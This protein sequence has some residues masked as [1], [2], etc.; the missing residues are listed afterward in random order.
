MD[1]DRNRLDTDELNAAFDELFP[2]GL[3][4]DDVKRILAPQGWANSPLLAV[5]HPS[6]QQQF[7]ESTRMHENLASLRKPGDTKPLSEPPTLEEFTA[8]AGP[9]EIRADEEVCRLVGMA[10]WDVFSD[11]HEVTDADGRLYDLG[12]FRG[13]GGFL[14]DLLNRHIGEGRTPNPELDQRNAELDAQLRKMM[15]GNDL[16]FE[17]LAK[18]NT[19][20]Y[21]YTDFYMGTGMVAGRTDIAPVYQMIFRRLRARGCDWKYTFPRVYAIDM[22]PLAESLKEKP[23]EPEWMNYSPEDSFA[24]EEENN[25]KDR[26][27]A[28]LRESLDEGYR[29]SLEAAQD[30]PPPTVVQAYE[31]IYGE[32]PSGWPPES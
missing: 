5:F 28:E 7:E 27:I 4:G 19:G 21:R 24:K 16:L 12:S 23:D 17:M 11:N 31:A 9:P 3:S 30:K 22:R 26:E 15:P 29:E 32:L 25:E 20:A 13:S 1:D 2:K 18:E 14:S 6:P 8:D 10:L